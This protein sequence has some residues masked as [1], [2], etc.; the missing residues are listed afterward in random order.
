MTPHTV[1]SF[2]MIYVDSQ[3][4]PCVHI[5]VQT[6]QTRHISSEET[7][8]DL[9]TLQ[10][11]DLRE[12]GFSMVEAAKVITWAQVRHNDCLPIQQGWIVLKDWRNAESRHPKVSQDCR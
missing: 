2:N 10:R 8:A 11:E 1:T 3:T 12:L 9:A 4:V 7:A 5:H 6:M